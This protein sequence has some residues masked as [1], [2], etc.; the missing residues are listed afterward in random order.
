MENV[1]ECELF[2]VMV[3]SKQTPSKTYENYENAEAEAVRLATQERR[4]TYVM[5]IIT[6]IELNDVKIVRL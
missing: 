6:R 2:A 1:T 3:D 5:K 4:T